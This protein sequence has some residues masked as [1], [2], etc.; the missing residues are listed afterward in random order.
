MN[1]STHRRADSGHGDTVIEGQAVVVAVDGDHVWLATL[2]PAACGSCATQ[3]ACG[4]GGTATT[5]KSQ[6]RAPRALPAGAA[7]LA[8]GDTVRVGVDRSALTRAAWVAYGLPLLAML[9]AVLPMQAAGDG[10]AAA[11]AVA[12]LLVGAAVARVLVKRWH[13]GLQP[14]VLGRADGHG[15]ARAAAPAHTPAAVPLS[16]LQRLDGTRSRRP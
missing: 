5:P 8:L 13:A 9:A 1:T 10:A 15:C 12:G 7:P 6:W 2:A 3:S 14:A 16:Q 4:S 11:A